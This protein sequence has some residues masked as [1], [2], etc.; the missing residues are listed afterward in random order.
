MDEIDVVLVLTF[1]E[2]YNRMFKEKE[3]E[4]VVQSDGKQFLLPWT[5]SS[6]RLEDVST[7]SRRES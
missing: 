2:A 7:S 4:I 1:L 3:R 6:G 5:K